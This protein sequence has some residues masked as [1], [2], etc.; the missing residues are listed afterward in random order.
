MRFQYEIPE[1][2]FDN[3]YWIVGRAADRLE[4]KE[5][6]FHAI[7]PD[8]LSTHDKGTAHFI[9]AGYLIKQQLY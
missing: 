8:Y 7:M 2:L 3:L 6:H 4:V 1:L 5:L 9:A